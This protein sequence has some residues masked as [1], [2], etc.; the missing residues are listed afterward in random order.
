[1]PVPL[2]FFFWIWRLIYFVSYILLGTVL[3]KRHLRSLKKRESEREN[4]VCMKTFVKVF[5]ELEGQNLI[6]SN[7]HLDF[8]HINVTMTWNFLLGYFSLRWCASSELDQ[9]SPW[10]VLSVCLFHSMPDSRSHI[11]FFLMQEPHVGLPHGWQVSTCL[12][13][14]PRCLGRKWIGSSAGST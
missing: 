5:S 2:V 8:P 14:H 3:L 13:C 1:M 6:Y 12:P 7:Q 4:L 10:T 11:V 9:T